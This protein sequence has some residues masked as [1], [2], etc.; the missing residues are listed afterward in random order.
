[1]IL[2]Y[3]ML[4]TRFDCRILCNPPNLTILTGNERWEFHLSIDA[5]IIEK[6]WMDAI[7]H[8]IWIDI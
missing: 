4:C 2:V 6:D 8:A 1:M 7:L 3:E 5:K